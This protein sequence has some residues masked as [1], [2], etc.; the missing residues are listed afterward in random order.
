[1]AVDG[2]DATDGHVPGSRRSDQAAAL[3]GQVSHDLSH[4]GTGLQAH[5]FAVVHAH[6]CQTRGVDDDHLGVR[7]RSPRHHQR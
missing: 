6:G 7:G 1:M 3:P 4:F 5:P 2:Q